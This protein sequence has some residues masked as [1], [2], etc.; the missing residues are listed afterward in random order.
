MFEWQGALS[1]AITTGPPYC[2]FAAFFIF[3]LII[4]FPFWTELF[5]FWTEILPFWTGK[6]IVLY[7][8]HPVMGGMSLLQTVH[9]T[10][11]A[12]MTY[13]FGYAFLFNNNHLL[14]HNYKIS[15]IPISYKYFMHNYTVASNYIYL[16]IILC[17][18]TVIWFHE[19]QFDTDNF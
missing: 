8:G 15:S 11:P 16:I 1:T 19:F 12:D 10:A 4:I 14:T 17:F 3:I 9:S 13:F 2:L 7:P 18:L 5:P 6:G